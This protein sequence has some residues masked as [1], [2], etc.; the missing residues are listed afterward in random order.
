[1]QIPFLD[2][3]QF[4]ADFDNTDQLRRLIDEVLLVGDK[5]H[6]LRRSHSDI[7][8]LIQAS[9][10]DATIPFK[11]AH[12]VGEAPK[13]PIRHSELR[14]MIGVPESEQANVLSRDTIKI[15]GL[16]GFNHKIKFDAAA[17]YKDRN[18]NWGVHASIV[19]DQNEITHAAI[20]MPEIGQVYFASPEGAYIVTF[21]SY[22]SSDQTPKIARIAIQSLS[23]KF[24]C[25]V[26]SWHTKERALVKT[27]LTMPLREEPI[28]I[29][30]NTDP[31]LIA[32]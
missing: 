15:K 19:N 3:E 29:N 25:E 2:T 28:I 11:L 13:S 26:G 23:P 24:N 16:D 20:Y 14:E 4:S 6:D 17:N 5:L 12:K 31:A 7:R 18:H 9:K 8:D 22:R 30:R 1:M 32:R 21:P 10:E 27:L